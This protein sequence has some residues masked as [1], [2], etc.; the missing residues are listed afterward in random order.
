MDQTLTPEAV[1]EIFDYRSDGELLWKR[2]SEDSFSNL[3][4]AR[5]W[6][7]R[8]AGKPAGRVAKH[9]YKQIKLNGKFYRAHRVVW[10]WHFGHWPST[11]IDHRNQSKTDNRI[12]NLR[13][14]TNGQNQ[15]NKKRRKD[16]TSGHVGVV[17]DYRAN[18][19]KAAVTKNH[20]KYHAG[21]FTNK[22]EAI[23]ARDILAKKLHGEFATTHEMAPSIRSSNESRYTSIDDK[24]C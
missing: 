2:R 22:T 4:T 1:R 6:N 9:G 18:R 17:W 11:Y 24:T 16:N 23:K 3:T 12:E 21:S 15:C 5:S 8:Y 10:C 20:K 13:E 14:A 19:W 7:A